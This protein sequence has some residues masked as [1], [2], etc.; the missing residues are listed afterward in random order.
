ME[1]KKLGN[2]IRQAREEKGLSQEKL[3]EYLEVSRQAVSK[4]ETGLAVPTEENLKRLEF[5]L[6]LAER[7]LSD[8]TQTA[9]AP[10]NTAKPFS[11]K[12][13]ALLAAASLVMIAGGFF[14]GRATAPAPIPEEP[15]TKTIWRMTASH[16]DHPNPYESEERSTYDEMGR[17]LKR[18]NLGSP[19][20]PTVRVN[21]FVYDENGNQ[22]EQRTYNDGKLIGRQEY[23]YNEDG[24]LLLYRDFDGENTLREWTEAAYDE[25]GNQISFAEYDGKGNLLNSGRYNYTYHE[26]GSYE[27]DFFTPVTPGTENLPWHVLEYYDPHGNWLKKTEFDMNGNAIRTVTFEYQSFEV[28]ADFYPS[29]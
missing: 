25:R 16:I 26:D 12:H 15:E 9:E 8:L 14:A 13:I 4:W 11:A 1:E 19:A 5:V 27:R 23:E 2:A 20:D 6:D 17:L 3:A 21:E 22:T 10:Q 24:R 28:P 18:E 29:P 7:S